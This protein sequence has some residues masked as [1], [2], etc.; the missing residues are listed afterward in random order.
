MDQVKWVLWRKISNETQIL[1]LSQRKDLSQLSSL[2]VWQ[3]HHAMDN[4]GLILSLCVWNFR[5]NSPREGILPWPRI[6]ETALL[7]RQVSAF[8]LL[9]TEKNIMTSGLVPFPKTAKRLQD[10]DTHFQNFILLETLILLHFLEGEN[11]QHEFTTGQMKIRESQRQRGACNHS[12]TLLALGT[13][14]F[15]SLGR[16]DWLQYRSS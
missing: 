11:S 7:K 12:T 13:W 3:S 2:A 9:S 6:T 1:D 14:C 10:H 8:P 16:G 15:L 4:A 5:Q